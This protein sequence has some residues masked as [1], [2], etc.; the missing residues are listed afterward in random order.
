M[1]N[2]DRETDIAVKLIEGVCR[3]HGCRIDYLN[4]DLY[5]KMLSIAGGTDEQQ[6][7]CAEELDRLFND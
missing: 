2:L 1:S 3:K 5:N 7:D 4:S 6:T